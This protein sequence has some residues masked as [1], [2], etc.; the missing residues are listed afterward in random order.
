MEPAMKAIKIV[1]ASA[2]LLT[3]TTAMAAAQQDRGQDRHDQEPTRANSPVAIAETPAF[4][5]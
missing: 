1:L 2:V 5:A 3:A 4:G